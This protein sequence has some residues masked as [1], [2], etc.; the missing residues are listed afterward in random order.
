M[1]YTQ[2][3]LNTPPNFTVYVF[4]ANLIKK[5]GIYTYGQVT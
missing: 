2:S 3:K 5:V 4:S 1:K